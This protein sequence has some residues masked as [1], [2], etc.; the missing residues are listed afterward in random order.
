MLKF[1]LRPTCK[2]AT[3]NLVGFAF[4]KLWADMA[5]AC[6]LEAISGAALAPISLGASI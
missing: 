4:I 5:K 2:Q 6:I 3:C 1:M